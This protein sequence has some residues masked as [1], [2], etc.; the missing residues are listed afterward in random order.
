MV[1]TWQLLQAN[2]AR[3]DIAKRCL[4]QTGDEAV[5]VSIRAFAWILQMR[6]CGDLANLTCVD[7]ANVQVGQM[8]YVHNYNSRLRVHTWLIHR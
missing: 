4:P 6:N 1:F 2:L 3:P 5:Q 7:I 8:S